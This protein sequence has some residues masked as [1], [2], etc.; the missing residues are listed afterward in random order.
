MLNSSCS[1]CQKELKKRLD[2]AKRIKKV[3]F[4]SDLK[5]LG[6]EVI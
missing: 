6:L 1:F 5:K 2:L 4:R 3:G